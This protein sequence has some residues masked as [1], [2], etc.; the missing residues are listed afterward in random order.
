ML[1][2]KIETRTSN[3]NNK[4]I[5]AKEKI[6]KDEIIW[7]I[8]PNKDTR[9]FYNMLRLHELPPEE[10]EIVKQHG[11]QVGYNILT[12]DTDDGKY[13]NHSCDPNSYNALNGE[14]VTVARRDIEVGEEITADYGTIMS[15][16]WYEDMIC[17]CGASNCRKLITKNDYNLPELRIIHA[18]RLDDYLG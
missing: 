4:G 11:Y 2:K 9:K 6:F 13:T 18:G 16:A 10:Y 14:W 1:N 17:N 3:I 15:H 12:V 5:F 7:S 8:D